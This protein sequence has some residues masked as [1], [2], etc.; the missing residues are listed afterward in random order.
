MGLYVGNAELETK[1]VVAWSRG[2]LGSGSGLMLSGSRL[3]LGLR[4]DM[5]AMRR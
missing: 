5:L 2:L 1:G 3:T 4:P